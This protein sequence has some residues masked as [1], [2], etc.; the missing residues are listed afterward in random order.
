M[1]S[2]AIVN[3]EVAMVDS[4]TVELKE[5]SVDETADGKIGKSYIIK[6]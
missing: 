1:S 5:D 2:S 3:R 4:E 6:C